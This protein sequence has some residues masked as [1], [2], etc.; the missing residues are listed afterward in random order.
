MNVAGGEA[1][2]RGGAKHLPL[3]RQQQEERPPLPSAVR[4]SRNYVRSRA[5]ENTVY[6]SYSWAL[7][8]LVC[9]LEGEIDQLNGLSKWSDRELKGCLDG[10]NRYEWTLRFW[11]DWS[12]DWFA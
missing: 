11:S 9:G 3:P 2:L 6:Y 12:S 5:G 8:G 7:A 10:N 4:H 1:S